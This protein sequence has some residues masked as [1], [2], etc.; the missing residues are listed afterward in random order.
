VQNN[1]KTL[2]WFDANKADIK[3]KHSEYWKE[4]QTKTEAE[5]KERTLLP[6]DGM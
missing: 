6:Q 1:D 3:T 4:W 2:Q 5:L